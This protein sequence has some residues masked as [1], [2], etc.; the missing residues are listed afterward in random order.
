LI[1][2]RNN[3]EITSDIFQEDRTFDL[4][5]GVYA[6]KLSVMALSENRKK[7]FIY[8]PVMLQVTERE[9][10]T[11]ED[12]LNTQQFLE[13]GFNSRT[14]ATPITGARFRIP[15]LVDGVPELKPALIHFV[16]YG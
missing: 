10:H 12:E 7:E 8:G 16:F 14:F 13:L 2:T 1:F 3:L 9:E 15:S 11:Y 5:A 4:D 6:R